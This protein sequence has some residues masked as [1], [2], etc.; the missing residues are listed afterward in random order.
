MSN[1]DQGQSKHNCS[2]KY[3]CIE[4]LQLIV[5]GEATPQQKAHFRDH[6]NE[7]MP[8]YQ[9]YHLDMAIR[10]LLKVKCNHEA[11][12]ELIESIKIKI[13]QNAPS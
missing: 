2:N 6:L 7:C 5:D 3:D 4:M 1:L 10:E 8:C 12:S 9:Q 13:S 11:P